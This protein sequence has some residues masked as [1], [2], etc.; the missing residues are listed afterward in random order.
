MFRYS[1]K[2][3]LLSAL[4][5]F[6][7]FITTSLKS[8]VLINEGFT[9]VDP[10]P[11]GW[12][13]QNLS[14]PAGTSNWFQ[15]NTTVFVANSNPT[16]SYA[17]ADYNSVETTG[18]NNWLFTPT[19][20]IQNG[21]VFSFYTRSNPSPFPDRLQLRM[22][23]NGTSVNAGTTNT[24]VGDFTTLLV[25]INPTIIRDGYP[26][27]WTKYTVTITGVPNLTTGRFAFRYF[28]ENGGPAGLGAEY[29]GIDDVQ[30]IGC[31]NPT[32]GGTIAG[33]QSGSTPFT[34]AAFTSTVAASG[35]AGGTLEYQWQSSTTSNI[36]GFI[37][38]PSTNSVTYDAGALTQTTWFRRL[39]RASCKSDWTDAAVS[40]VLQVTVTYASAASSTPTLCINTALLPNITHNT[41]GATGISNDNVAG[42]NGLPAGV[43]AQWAANQITISGTPTESGIFTYSIPLTGGI[44]SIN[45]TGTIT[46]TAAPTPTFTTQPGATACVGSDVT[47]TTESG[48]TNYVW[49]VPGTVNVDYS[50]TSGGVGTSSNTVTL[51]WLTAGSKTVTINYT[52]G[53]CTAASATSSTPTTVSALPTP[54]ISAGGATT[55]CNGGSVLLTA[56]NTTGNVKL[57]NALTFTKTSSRYVSVP[58][59]ASLNL[60][61]F[62]MEAWVN[63]S[64]ENITIIDKGNY[65]FLWSLNAN[66]NGNKMGFY[67]NSNSTWNYS[68]AAVA[69]NTW[70]HVAITL[71]GGTLTFY[72]NGVAS[73]TASVGSATTDNIEMN[74][75]R[76]QPSSC[77]C[78]H[79][80]GTMDELRI[81]NVA[82]SQSDILINYESTVPT[83]SSNLVA[84]YKFDESTGTTT[85]DASG[86]GNN[87]TLVNGPTWQVP[88]TSP[89]LLH[90]DF[91]WYNG[92]AN[93]GTTQSITATT[94]GSYTVKVTLPNGCSATSGATSVVNS[95][96]TAA[97]AGLDQTG[98]ATC[99]LTQVTLAGNTPTVGTGTGAL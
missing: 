46:V 25:D 87:G 2:K 60:S 84:Y 12:A 54:T 57:G 98:S 69:Q 49:T 3:V 73:G 50:I 29:I 90:N 76:Q 7:G 82:R 96:P 66:G 1:H 52:S 70:T 81:W 85:A 10:L 79:F 5:L 31:F 63:Y 4:V 77:R 61:D 14:T 59:S 62:T 89:V 78:N 47:Y 92:A 53:A 13:K 16:N 91:I 40:N 36:A 39:A 33:A 22:S 56:R 65:N 23:T 27:L 19:V 64:G 30:Y 15:G 34:P 72:I 75:G 38:I 99:G 55:F 18:I 94:T 95:S 88:S 97:A 93:I 86:N 35:Q 58:H 41:T 21:C 17:A 80:N 83:N 48:Q 42:A 28:V 45:A 20:D 11:T 32:V 24:S 74:I 44:G 8:Q 71:S 43:K 67:S 37:D 68:S 6:L 51:K 9:T 26:Y